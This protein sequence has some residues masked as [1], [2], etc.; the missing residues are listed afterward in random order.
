[1][2]IIFTPPPNYLT[3]QINNYGSNLFTVMKSKI[4]SEILSEVTPEIEDKVEQ[5]T[6]EIMKANKENIFLDLS[7]LSEEQIKALFSILQKYDQKIYHETLDS[8]FTDFTSD[9]FNPYLE[10]QNGIGWVETANAFEN[11]EKQEVTYPEFV[12]LFEGGETIKSDQ[13]QIEKLE[14]DKA[15]L[16]EALEKSKIKMQDNAR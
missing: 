5:K 9:I 2:L 12:K 10:F 13:T 8:L 1:M 3:P 16:L 6:L 7:K 11:T 4:L 14:A 15:E